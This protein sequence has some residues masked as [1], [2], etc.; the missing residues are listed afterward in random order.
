M[1]DMLIAVETDM[2]LFFRALAKLR[3]DEPLT[4]QQAQAHFVDCFYDPAKRS[5]VEQEQL[6]AWVQ[7][8]VVRARRD[9]LTDR[10]RADAMNRV[11]PL[12]V[13]RN[14]LLQEVI[15]RVEKGDD[16]AITELMDVLRNPYTE[17]PGR[18]HFAEKRPEWARSRAGCS[19]LS[20]SS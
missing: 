19:T 6:T 20:C 17:Q 3:T 18:E 13:P 7:D 14:Y 16:A 9:G 10:V 12:Y 2:T 4:H 8:Y 15:E 5:Q 1:S 11:N